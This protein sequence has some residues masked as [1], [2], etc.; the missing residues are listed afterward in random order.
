MK[1]RLA[2][3]LC[4][5]IAGPGMAQDAQAL[6]KSKCTSCHTQ[7]KVLTALR[8]MPEAERPA[9]LD[10]FLPGHFAPDAAERKAI[11]EYLLVAAAKS[12]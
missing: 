1:L 9:R 11:A 2:W 6:F 10:K 8:K 5:M 3:L 4:A 7:K 12:D